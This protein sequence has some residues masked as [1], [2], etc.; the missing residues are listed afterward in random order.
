M[1]SLCVALLAFASVTSSGQGEPERL[2]PNKNLQERE[3]AGIYFLFKHG[4]GLLQKLRENLNL[5]C[6]DHQVVVL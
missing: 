1:R 6:P 5:E 2:P 3:I 4:T